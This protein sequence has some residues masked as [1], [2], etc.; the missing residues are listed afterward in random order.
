M[1]TRLMQSHTRHVAPTCSH[2]DGER[3]LHVCALDL[4]RLLQRLPPFGLLC[5]PPKCFNPQHSCVLLVNLTEQRRSSGFVDPSLPSFFKF[6]KRCRRWTGRGCCVHMVVCT[7]SRTSK[8]IGDCVGQRRVICIATS[9]NFCSPCAVCP[10]NTEK[11]AS[12]SRNYQREGS[13]R[14]RK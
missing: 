8:L 13:E 12:V 6:F 9:T 1:C 14:E 7:R 11:R 10:G 3:L 2:A 4:Q 5:C